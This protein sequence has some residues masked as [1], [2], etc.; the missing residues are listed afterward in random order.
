MLGTY[1]QELFQWIS[2][3]SG[4][5]S[6]FA[7]ATILSEEEY[8]KLIGIDI[9][10]ER[11]CFGAIEPSDEGPILTSR[12]ATKSKTGRIRLHPAESIVLEH[13]AAPFVRLPKN[14]VR[15]LRDKS[16]MIVG[17][18][19]GGSEIAMNLA[20][21]GV[22][23]LELVDFD[24]VH[25]ENY[26]RFPAGMQ[27]LGRH[28]VDVVRSMIHER[29]L[30][31][32]VDVHYLNVVADANEFRSLLSSEIDLIVCAADSVASRRLVNCTSVQMGF[33]C[34]IA[35]TL[36]GGRIGEI[37]RVTPFS[38]PC[39]ECVRL[40]LG[41]VLE[42]TESVE[43][44]VT[45]YVGTEDARLDGGALKMDIMI[46]AALASHVALQ[47]LNP[48]RFPPAPAPYIVW[49]REAAHRFSDPFQFDCPFATNFVPIKRRKDCPVCGALTTELVG[50]DVTERVREILSQADQASG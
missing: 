11:L 46:V 25:P 31:T 34:I 30:S 39:Y 23:R 29:E 28:K 41:A 6:K 26:I 2:V 13:E 36:D 43:G 40:E 10:D 37:L 8:R 1:R 49:G 45:P 14:M 7:G 3:E 15:D 24:R 33:E 47:V 44:A 50:V 4:F 16:A 5:H 12:V 22:G 9:V 20:C 21:S 18:G 48:T 32:T 35:G 27:E 17:V 38:S 42:D 19:S